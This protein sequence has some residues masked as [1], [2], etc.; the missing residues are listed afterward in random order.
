MSPGDRIV[1][2]GGPWP[3]RHGAHGAI[4]TG[5]AMYPFHSVSKHEVVILLDADPIPEDDTPFGHRHDPEWTCV[6]CRRDLVAERS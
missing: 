3:E 1:V 5:P 6:I 4:V 2:V